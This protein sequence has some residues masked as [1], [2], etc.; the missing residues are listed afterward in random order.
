MARRPV[1]DTRQDD[2]IQKI[3]DDPKEITYWIEP[4]EQ[5]FPFNMLR[6]IKRARR[7]DLIH[8]N[9]ANPFTSTMLF[10]LKVLGGKRVIIDWEDWDGVGGYID[11]MKKGMISRFALG[12]FEEVF[13]KS[14]ALVI[15]V[16]KALEKRAMR[17]GIPPN[18]ILYVPNGFD[19]SLFS[20]NLSGGEFRKKFGLEDRPVIL[21]MSALHLFEKDNWGMILRSMRYVVDEV[22]NAT[23]LI[24]GGGNRSW[25]T[26]YAEELHLERNLVCTGYIPRTLVPAAIA[27]ADVAVHVLKDNNFFRSSSPM[28][29]PE[30]MAMRKAI[31]A[32]DVGEI[33]FMLDNGVGMLVKDQKPREFGEAILKLLLN[34]GLRERLGR[35]ASEKAKT[36]YSYRVLA[37]K[38]E[39]SYSRIT[40]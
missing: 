34:P 19:E 3:S 35:S 16:S 39:E 14:C 37:Q 36:E 38:I 31:V 25:V 17:L 13:P 1:R 22:P 28:V 23:L 27:S 2:S 26:K 32:S 9:R 15:V 12:F 5:S 20:E 4:F 30:Y 40:T 7:F 18:K 33:H 8:V 21:F 10:P 29:I 6:L 24:V 11:I